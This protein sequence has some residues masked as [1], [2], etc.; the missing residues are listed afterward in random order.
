MAHEAQQRSQ[1]G[2]VSLQHQHSELGVF[3][4]EGCGEI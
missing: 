2:I 1:A 4:N 3:T